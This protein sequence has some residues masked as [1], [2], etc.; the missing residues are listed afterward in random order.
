M[1]D[2]L[3]IVISCF[4]ILFYFYYKTRFVPA[5]VSAVVCLGASLVAKNIRV[6]KEFIGTDSRLFGLT[7]LFTFVI[8]PLLALLIY[9]FY[10]AA[11]YNKDKT[12]Y[13]EVSVI[14]ERSTSNIIFWSLIILINVAYIAIKN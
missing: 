4:L 2:R 9:L 12:K 10:H 5:I 8:I 6:I 13:P 11:Q 7:I 3:G 1:E 14:F